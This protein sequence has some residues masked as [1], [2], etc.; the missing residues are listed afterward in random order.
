MTEKFADEY[1]EELSVYFPTVEEKDFKRIIK[2]LTW[3]LSDYMRIYARG[4]NVRS[5]QTL[6]GDKK[7]KLFVVAR[8]FGKKHL[9]GMRKVRREKGV[10]F[11]YG[12]KI[13]KKQIK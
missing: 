3:R 7:L 5:S 11:R 8:I 4:F 13:A 10:P 1:A 2:S 6:L 9:N 12:G